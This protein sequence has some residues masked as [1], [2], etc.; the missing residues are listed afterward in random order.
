MMTVF[1]AD[2]AS[3]QKTLTIEQL[4]DAGFRAIN[5]KISHGMTQKAVH[6]ALTSYITQARARDMYVST[7]HYLDGASSGA[8]Q[9][10]YAWARM[11]ELG[12]TDA[13]HTVD[14]ENADP[15]PTE[16]VYREYVQIMTALLKRPIATYTG[17]WWQAAHPWLTES[18]SSPWLWAAP[19][20]GYLRKYP[21]DDSPD[22]TAGYGGWSK[23]S[24]MQYA[25]QPIGG[26]A[27]SQSAVRSPQ[28]WDAM[29]GKSV[30]AWVVIPASNSLFSE[31]DTLAPGRRKASDGTIGDPA[32]AQESSDHNPDETGKTPYEDN[33]STNE[34]HAA[35]IDST[36][37]LANWNMQKCVDIIVGRCRT[38]IEKRVRYIIYNRK[39][40]S[41]S[42][43]W[44]SWHDYTGAS[45]HTEHAHFSFYYGSGNGDA[46]PENITS[47]WGLLE[48]K[49]LE[50]LM[51]D[52][53]QVN[54]N[55]Y[56]DAWWQSRLADSPESKALPDAGRARSA[57]RVAPWHQGTGAKGADPDTFARL[58]STDGIDD[59]LSRVE[60][61][62]EEIK[63]AVVS[64]PPT[65]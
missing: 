6:P 21:G 48:R 47:P 51:A 15:M 43:G 28:V 11:M 41:A 31:F 36:L 20:A 46:N 5:V 44:D 50:D 7:F 38:G 57:L 32:H 62:V 60:A 26:I 10:G 18:E 8:S 63:T 56:M 9:A 37:N 14:V 29:R 2:I 17:D 27:V 58:F 34:V 30:T 19:N 16:A 53:T 33:D 64:T 22:W 1:I 39:I 23:L 59:R 55:S 54:F 13:A 25:V 12:L 35:D 61:A 4:W 3:Y 52:F 65:P 24:A 42:W 45:A 49:A 40:I